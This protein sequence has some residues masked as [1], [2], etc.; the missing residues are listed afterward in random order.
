MRSG[1]NDKRECPECGGE[2]D[3]YSG[4]ECGTTWYDAKEIDKNSY[5][6]EW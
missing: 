5:D 4:C 2:L 3:Y 1:E 6:M